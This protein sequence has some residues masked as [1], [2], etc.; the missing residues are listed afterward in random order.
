MRRAHPACVAQPVV[1][2]LGFLTVW[3]AANVTI[4]SVGVGQDVQTFELDW[5]APAACPGRAAVLS[6]LGQ[7]GPASGLENSALKAR[8]RVT[9]VHSGYRLHLQLTASGTSAQRTLTSRDCDA[10]AQATAVLIALA[11]E[12][13]STAAE[14][15]APPERL[16][17]ATNDEPP[18]ATASQTRASGAVAPARN[19]SSPSGLPVERSSDA[20]D[21]A[22]QSQ[23]RPAGS[24]LELAFALGAGAAMDVGT[25]PRSPAWGARLALGLQ[26]GRLRA[27][28][29]FNLWP[30]AAA[31]SDAY[32]T[33]RLEGRGWT[34]ELALGLQFAVAALAFTP[35]VAFE[36]GQ[37]HVYA[38]GIAD[39]QPAGV[40]W[41]AAGGGVRAALAVASRLELA[42]QVHGLVPFERARF[43][44]RTNAGDV[45]LFTSAPIAL[46]IALELSYLIE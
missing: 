5:D 12:A 19:E 32:A 44:L 40:T 27:A 29:D 46:R 9:A 24:A 37:L 30:P 2:K 39:S 10:L 33:A 42:L 45:P 26:V 3:L 8:A 31:K 35:E 23:E 41:T 16:A 13:E 38:Q 18:S 15:A 7:R 25:L 6:L 17:A 14:V 22:A 20:G 34:A 1:R 28:F 43:L 36:Y 11:L 4:V 21:D